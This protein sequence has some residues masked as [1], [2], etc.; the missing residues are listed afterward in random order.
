VLVS[1]RL[2][3]QNLQRRRLLHLVI[4]FGGAGFISKA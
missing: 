2:K 4:T 3:P 1:W